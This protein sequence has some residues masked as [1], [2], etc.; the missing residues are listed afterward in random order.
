MS[1]QWSLGFGAVANAIRFLACVTVLHEPEFWTVDKDLPVRSTAFY[2]LEKKW[3]NTHVFLFMLYFVSFLYHLLCSLYVYVLFVFDLTFFCYFILK[4]VKLFCE[5]L[6]RSLRLLS[7]CKGA[8]VGMIHLANLRWLQAVLGHL[9]S[10]FD[11]GC[12]KY[13]FLLFYFLGSVD[14]KRRNVF[15]FPFWIWGL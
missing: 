4:F 1:P 12:Y 5:M 13:S 3:F 8:E 6:P 2:S 7:M 10:L 11:S 14:G 15:F 9:V